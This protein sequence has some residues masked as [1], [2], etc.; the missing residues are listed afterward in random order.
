MCPAETL[1]LPRKEVLLLQLVFCRW[2]S[3]YQHEIKG[4][5]WI[6]NVYFFFALAAV[7]QSWYM[8]LGILLN[9]KFCLEPNLF[10]YSSQCCVFRSSKFLKSLTKKLGVHWSS[11]SKVPV[12]EHI[13][14]SLSYVISPWE[15][16]LTEERDKLTFVTKR[17]LIS[18]NQNSE[19]ARSSLLYTQFFFSHET[20]VT[21][22][23]NL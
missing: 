15:I 19:T 8:A 6:E 9:H 1:L 2:T 22:A 10:F 4:H 7:Q 12:L 3:P 5:L 16:M 13:R 20:A 14:V 18:Y 23:W 17:Y 11:Y 21:V